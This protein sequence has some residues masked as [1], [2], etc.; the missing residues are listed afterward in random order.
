MTTQSVVEPE[1]T[2]VIG[3]VDTHKNTHYAAAVDSHGRLLGPTSSPPTTA[4]MPSC[5]AGSTATAK[6]LQSASK[7]PGPS[8]PPRLATSP[9]TRFE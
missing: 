3:G 4:A 7:A 5:W 8:V 1:E 2:V 9:P 6:W